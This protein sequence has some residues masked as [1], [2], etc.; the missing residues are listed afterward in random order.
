MKKATPYIHEAGSK[1]LDK[2][3]TKIR[4]NKKYKTD[5]KDL[6]GAGIDIHKAIGKLPKPK[7]GFVSPG[8]NYLGPYNP[9]ES[10]LNYDPKTEEIIEIFQQPTGLLDAAAMQHDIDYSV[11]GD[12]KKCK[13]EAD[14]KMVKTFK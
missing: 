14:R 2:I 4:P 9:L 1:A 11:C 8:F 10:Q 7:K 13:H 5:R 6:D 12:N 3:S